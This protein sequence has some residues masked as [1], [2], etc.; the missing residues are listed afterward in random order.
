[1][2]FPIYFCPL[3]KLDVL[4]RADN[5]LALLLHLLRKHAHL[6]PHPTPGGL[7]RVVQVVAALKLCIGHL[8]RITP[9]VGAGQF[10]IDQVVAASL[11][12]Q[13]R[14][15]LARDGLVA[16][17]PGFADFI[18]QADRH[19]EIKDLL[20]DGRVVDVDPRQEVAQPLAELAVVEIGLH[21]A[22]RLDL[23]QDAP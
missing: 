20:A 13:G 14:R 5:Y 8:D 23:R 17:L 10:V 16:H 11:Q 7:G 4:T 21:D 15:S 3:I 18:E 6:F 19:V 9:Q 22:H 1:M 12:D 2:T